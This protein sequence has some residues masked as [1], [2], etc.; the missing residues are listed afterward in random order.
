MA[1]TI[2]AVRTVLDCWQNGTRL[3]FHGDFFDLT[4][5]PPTLSPGPNPYGVPPLLAGGVGP[6]MLRMVAAHAD[7]LLVH[8]FNTDAYLRE[9]LMTAV[10]AGL[11]E[12]GR[13]RDGFSVVL[14]VIVAAARTE[15]EHQRALAGARSMVAFYASTPA[16][17]PVLAAEGYED[18]QPELHAL[19]KAG[20]WSDTAAAVD[21]TLLHRLVVAGTPAEA[22]KAL[23]A[24]TAL[25]GADRLGFYLPYRADPG[26]VAEVLDALRAPANKEP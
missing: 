13:S 22:A 14:D 10:E 8:P 11:H 17:R 1:E 26:C 6:R 4:L 19:I 9:H 5:M 2:H 18:L 24:R 16:Y 7:G 12:A 21:D 23:A 20:R 25:V 15:E 3:D